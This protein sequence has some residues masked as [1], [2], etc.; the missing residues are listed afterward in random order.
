MHKWLASVAILLLTLPA[1]A[2]AQGGRG[3]AA[4]GPAR[5]AAGN[6]VDIPGWWARLDD[7]KEPRQGL[8]VTRK[9]TTIR[10]TTGPNAIFFDPQE[11]WEGQY[12][13]KATFT[14]LKPASHQVAYGLF[15]GGTS[16]DQNS[17]RYS[18]LVVRQDGK[19]LIKKR[20][21]A[22]T[23]NVA[24]DWADHAAVAKADASG[25]QVNELAI[26]VAKDAVTF[27][28]NGQEVAKH[29]A[30]AV[31]I[32]G[33]AGLRIGHGLDLQ[34]DNFSVTDDRAAARTN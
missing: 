8:N 24:G 20:N 34:I 22:A 29:P 7:P 31:D 33:V 6:G 13:I 27:T 26:K 5:P 25:R 16:L 17:Q 28:I 23:P 21:G 15:F 12:T 10:A 11:D 3:G 1:L 32:V 18:Y 30:S 2:E 14:Q 19:Y 9:G 4:A